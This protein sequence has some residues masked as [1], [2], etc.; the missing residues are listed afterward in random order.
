MLSDL[1]SANLL[2]LCWECHD[3]LGFGSV[4]VSDPHL[5][6]PCGGWFHHWLWLAYYKWVGN[7]RMK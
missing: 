3:V 7:W 6:V 2:K 4:D 1:V 5:L